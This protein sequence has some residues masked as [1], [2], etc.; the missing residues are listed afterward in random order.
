MGTA[1]SISTCAGPP[2]CAE[3]LSERCLVAS[4]GLGAVQVLVQNCHSDAYQHDPTEDLCALACNRPERLDD[5]KDDT[6]AQG[7]APS[8]CLCS[9]ELGAPA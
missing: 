4:S 6:G 1:T 5:T 2:H 8:C 3:G 7:L 9:I